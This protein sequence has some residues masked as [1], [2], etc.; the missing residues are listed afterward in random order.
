SRPLH[1]AAQ[2]HRRPGDHALLRVDEDLRAEATADVGGDDPELVHG[3]AQHERA[4]DEAVY[5]RV[6]RGDVQ[7]QLISAPVVAGDRGAW[8][9]RS[10]NESVVD[11]PAADDPG[12]VG[13]GGIGGLPVA[14]RPGEAAV[15]GGAVVQAFDAAVICFR[16]IGDGG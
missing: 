10:G 9:D 4:H 5:V 2:L 7:G 13:E 3:D 15:V 14:Q 11:E 8:L 1:R 6:L 12:R 16:R